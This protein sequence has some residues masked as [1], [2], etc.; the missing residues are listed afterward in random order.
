M[1]KTKIYS[2][3]NSKKNEKIPAVL[4]M[5]GFVGTL[6]DGRVE[7]ILQELTKKG[8]FGIGMMYDGIE[9]RGNKV[10]CNF[11]LEVYL[12]NMKEAFEIL[13]NNPKVDN[14]RVGIIASSISGAIFAYGIAN[15]QTNGIT[16]R[17]YVAI[18]PLMGWEYFGNE[19]QRYLLKQAR[20]RKLLKDF[21]I[22][23][24]YDAQRGIKRVLPVEC[25]KEMEKIDGILELE[26]NPPKD[27]E[28]LTLI[29][30]LDER[31]SP[32]SMERAHYVLGGKPE[33]LL[34]FI[35]GHALPIDNIEKPIIKFFERTLKSA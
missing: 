29:G 31:A 32:G 5:P 20:E 8:I 22:T 19:E 24:I 27:L 3:K 12:Q 25:T 15:N 1:V 21:E 4:G 14:E 23:S 7:Q 11:N 2:A 33:N 28:T 34:R 26:K 17:A 9:K 6:K 13:Y 35:T 18:S 10:T 16:P 30:S